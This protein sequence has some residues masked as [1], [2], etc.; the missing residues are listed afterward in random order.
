MLCRTRPC[1]R[2]AASSTEGTTGFASRILLLDNHLLC[3]DKP[4]GVL[5]Q[6]DRTQDLDIVSIG[7]EYLCRRYEKPNRA[8]LGLVHRL[9]RP[10][11]GAMVFARTSKAAGRLSELFRKRQVEKHYI[12]LVR[13]TLS[14]NGFLEN[15]LEY[16]QKT[17]QRRRG[18][19]TSY[20]SRVHEMDGKEIPGSH[21]ARLKWTSLG[22][23]WDK[24]YSLL[25]VQLHTGRKHQIRAQLAHIGHPIANDTKYGSQNS[26]DSDAVG[27]GPQWVPDT[28]ATTSDRSGGYERIGLHAHV[29]RF[30]HPV[31]DLQVEVRAPMPVAWEQLFP[32][33]VLL[34]AE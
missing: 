11:S 1:W 18:K 27:Q 3:V 6:G 10:V 20:Q 5:S 29:L 32:P 31:R 2:K 7:K 28:W 13:G 25:S 12:A 26:N 33:E 9:D 23:S 24:Q 4:A 8:Y 21:V 34:R 17:V 15:R 16:T 14:G 19:L 30:K 22:S